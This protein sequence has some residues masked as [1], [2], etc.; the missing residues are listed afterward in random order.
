MKKL[1]KKNNIKKTQI[2]LNFQRKLIKD[3]EYQANVYYSELQKYPKYNRQQFEQAEARYFL[4][5]L[6]RQA[7]GLDGPKGA[8]LNML[9]DSRCLENFK[10]EYAKLPSDQKHLLAEITEKTMKNMMPN[11][12]DGKTTTGS[13]Y[14]QENYNNGEN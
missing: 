11:E 6:K 4:E 3:L 10:E 14:L 12:I 9:D 1:L 13:Q 8:L 2:A 7:L 5:N